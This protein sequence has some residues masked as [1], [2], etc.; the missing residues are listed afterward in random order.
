VEGNQKN[1]AGKILHYHSEHHKELGQEAM[2]KK[3]M[4]SLNN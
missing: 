2:S 3:H 1:E 4:L